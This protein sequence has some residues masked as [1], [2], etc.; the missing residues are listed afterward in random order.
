MSTPSPTG[1]PHSQ[2]SKLARL[3][4]LRTRFDRVAV[5]HPSVEAVVEY[6]P[7]LRHEQ[8]EREALNLY[9]KPADPASDTY[10]LERAEESK[11]YY[12]AM[13]AALAGEERIPPLQLTIEEDGRQLY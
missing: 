13:R 11:G 1:E 7:D 10:Y 3:E 12:T 5:D 6:R 8:C 4:E 2:L 9:V